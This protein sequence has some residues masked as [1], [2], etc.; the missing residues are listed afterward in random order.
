[1]ITRLFNHAHI[2][3]QTG[4]DAFMIPEP[5]IGASLDSNNIIVLEQEGRHLVI[6][7]ATVPEL[8]RLLRDLANR[9]ATSE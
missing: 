6:N 5:A 7:R 2:L 4:D 1:M 9:G 8:R 3:F